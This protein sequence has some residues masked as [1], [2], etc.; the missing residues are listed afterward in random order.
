MCTITYIKVTSIDGKEDFIW[1]SKT[2]E[3][4]NGIL[5]VSRIDDALEE[6]IPMEKN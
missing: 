6:L 4:K 2:K 5:I 3:G 1:D